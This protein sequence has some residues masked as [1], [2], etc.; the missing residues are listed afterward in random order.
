[1]QH[2]HVHHPT[3]PSFFARFGCSELDSLAGIPKNRHLF[4]REVPED[5]GRGHET[6]PPAPFRARPSSP[7]DHARSR[8]FAGPGDQAS[9]RPGRIDPAAMGAPPP[10]L[11]RQDPGRGGM[12]R[13]GPGE[14]VGRGQRVKG[15]KGKRVV[16]QAR[17]GRGPTRFAS[18]TPLGSAAARPIGLGKRLLSIL[19]D[20]AAPTAPTLPRRENAPYP[21]AAWVLA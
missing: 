18:P 11:L 1:M 6:A 17:Q 13:P 16:G 8:F 20:P 14:G 3:H 7:R 21:R 9:G 15:R 2:L 10:R 5:R 4:G 19:I 12:G